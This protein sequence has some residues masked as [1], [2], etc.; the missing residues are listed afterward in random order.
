MIL[1]FSPNPALERVALVEPFETT[2]EKKKRPMRVTTFAGGS[3]MRAASVIRLLG[4]DVLA[5]GFVGGH[6]GSL[7]RD[8]LDRQ[9]IPHVLTPIAS[10]TRG[11][12][13]LLD[14]ERGVVTDV[15]ESAPTFTGEEADRLIGSLE[16]HL[17][18]ASLLILVDG[19]D[20]S[21][22][23]FFSRA[24][25]AARAANVPVIADL[26]GAALHT[27]VAEG[28]FLIRVNLKTLQKQT[29]RSLQHDYAILQEA[30]AMLA[31][32]VGH[33]VVT[34]AEEGA[35]LVNADGAW[36]IKAPIV[37]YFNPTGSGETLAGALAVH[38]ERTQDM[39]EAVRYGCAAAS[40]NVTHDEPGYA[41]PGE[42]AILFPRTT[43]VPVTVR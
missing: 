12:F 22:P 23:D 14:R 11:T 8:G 15:P 2:S 33:V 19:Q 41:T 13:L 9:D 29:E 1:T 5:I 21:D 18:H 36:R 35:L 26:C 31:Q 38:W 43:A 37:S 30:R 4:G 42:V 27:A 17:P 20:E 7:L 39:V 25:G 28:A 6:L 40:V 24:L 3:G 32:G 34:L 16:R 10:D